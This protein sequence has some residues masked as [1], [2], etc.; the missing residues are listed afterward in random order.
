MSTPAHRPNS[1]GVQNWR[2]PLPRA[3]S[4]GSPQ[5]RVRKPM[6][7][8]AASETRRSRVHGKGGRHEMRFVALPVG[9]GDAFFCETSDGFR[10][11]VDGGRSRRHLPTLFARFAGGTGVD[12]LVCTH[13]DADHAEGVI[14]FLESGLECA[15]LW[16]PDTWVAALL[17]LPR[18]ATETWDFML[19][20]WR[21]GT[22]PEADIAD[23]QEAAW[24]RMF[25]QSFAPD[26]Q[27]P[28]SQDT[29]SVERPE[30]VPLPLGHV[31]GEVLPALEQHRE[32]P[33]GVDYNGGLVLPGYGPPRYWM[34]EW[35]REYGP[36]FGVVL[37]DIGR[38]LNLVWLALD[39]GL[40]VRCFRYDRSSPHP[41]SG[42]PL[43]PL[44]ARPVMCPPTG[45][46]RTPEDFLHFAFLT[47][48]NRESLVFYL[49]GG[50]LPGVLFTA[51]SDLG[52]VNLQGV[53]MDSIATAP[54]HGSKDNAGAY[55]R[56]G[57]SMV[58]V[59]SDGYS[60]LRPCDEYL[61][62]PGTRYCTLCRGS[63][64]PKQAIRLSRGTDG[65]SPIETR[66]CHCV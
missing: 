39:R 66:P 48:L 35:V 3:A 29:S 17:A 26:Q 12:V 33:F 11:L 21:L 22:H 61:A 55:Q 8:S 40:P 58:W 63:N 59:R 16:L 53:V 56:V 14:G 44:N 10:V 24:R 65:W 45:V 2:K 42:Y 6:R 43:V 34:W 18:N 46:N 57:R 37:K 36:A 41:V 60:K 28:R 38:L 54:H 30:H 31:L 1:P 51:D 15:E 7:S 47:T 5:R 20:H 25:P 27:R 62:A 50:R 64:K 52:G 4:G 9:Q 49:E 19:K 32:W 23:L 13:N